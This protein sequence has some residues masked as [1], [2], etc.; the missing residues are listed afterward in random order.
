MPV[1]TS[2]GCPS[3][4]VRL[5]FPLTQSI[6]DGFRLIGKCAEKVNVF[7][8]AFFIDDDA[9]R[10]RVEPVL[11]KDRIDPRDHVFVACIIFD[12]NRDIARRPCPPSDSASAGNF[13]LFR[14]RIRFSSSFVS[15][16]VSTISTAWQRISVA[17]TYQCNCATGDQYAK[18]VNERSA[19]LVGVGGISTL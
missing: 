2:T 18:K 16:L 1:S 9:D 15:R 7:Y 12:A 17:R 10:N 8:L 14:S 19:I 6:G 13:I 5:E 3:L 4:Q 11:G